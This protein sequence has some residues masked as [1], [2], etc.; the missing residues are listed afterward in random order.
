MSNPEDIISFLQ[1][2]WK[3]FPLP[4]KSVSL[5]LYDP[6]D[7]SNFQLLSIAQMYQFSENKG[8]WLTLA[9][10]FSLILL[11]VPIAI[12]Y[13]SY[14][15]FNNNKKIIITLFWGEIIAH[16]LHFLH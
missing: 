16:L 14:T 5:I 1:L 4:T 11:E 8:G 6:F 10:I 12:A 15:T 7:L 13:T 9:Q 3:I 2:E